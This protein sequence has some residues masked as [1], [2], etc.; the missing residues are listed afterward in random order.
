MQNR[1]ENIHAGENKKRD[2]GAGLLRY[3]HNGDTLRSERWRPGWKRGG[4]AGGGSKVTPQTKRV[5]IMQTKHHPSSLIPSSPADL[6]CERVNFRSA[7][8]GT[9]I[10]F[11]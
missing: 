4:G 1:G 6:G 3:G 8:E 11:P 10:F 9:V 2:V 7:R 5:W